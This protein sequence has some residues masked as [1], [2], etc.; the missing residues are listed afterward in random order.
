MI[1]VYVNI[2]VDDLER[3]IEFYR[4]GIGLTLARRLFSDSTAEMRGASAVIFLSAKPPGSLPAQGSINARDYRR[5]WTPVHL[6]FVVESIEVAVE[7]AQRAGATLERGIE[8]HGPWG[9]GAVLSDPFG[10]GFCLL[11][12]WPD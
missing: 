4:D 1:R 2:D 12:G 7:R 11:E 8:D 9:M 5:H 6:D 10:N 3:S